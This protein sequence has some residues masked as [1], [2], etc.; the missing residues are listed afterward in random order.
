MAT[1]TI[2][3]AAGKSNL[4]VAAVRTVVRKTAAA[5]NGTATAA[6]RSGAFSTKSGA[7]V[8]SA[9]KAAHSGGAGTGR[10]KH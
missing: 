7:A 4:T 3:S 1:R 9:Q 5:K 2:K 8:G 10:Q 6:G